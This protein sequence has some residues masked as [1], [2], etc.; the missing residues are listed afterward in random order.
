MPAPSEAS[1]P[2][3]TPATT[4]S[5]LWGSGLTRAAAKRQPNSRAREPGSA[6]PVAAVNRPRAQL[7]GRRPRVGAKGREP[8]AVGRAEEVDLLATAACTPAGC[9]HPRQPRARQRLR[10]PIDEWREGR[11]VASALA[12]GS[13]TSPSPEDPEGQPLRRGRSQGSH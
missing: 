3:R 7:A 6:R 10:F 13:G 11:Q 1:E 4:P 8:Q 9:H 5:K 2:R 12:R